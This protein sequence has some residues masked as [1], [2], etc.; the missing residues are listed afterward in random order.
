MSY[1]G[2]FWFH[3][4]YLAL[5]AVS[6]VKR[7]KLLYLEALVSNLVLLICF[8]HFNTPLLDIDSYLWIRDSCFIL[9]SPLLYWQVILVNLIALVPIYC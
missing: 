4:I 3:S 6:L 2:P 1:S 9:I 8:A 5:T 7:E